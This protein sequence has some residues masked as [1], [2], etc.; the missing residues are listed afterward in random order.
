M[1]TFYFFL[2]LNEFPYKFL[3]D[4]HL[5]PSSFLVY[6][7]CVGSQLTLQWTSML[8]PAAAERTKVP[9]NYKDPFCSRRIHGG[10]EANFLPHCDTTES[11]SK[12]TR[13]DGILIGGNVVWSH[14]V[15]KHHD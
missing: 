14:L 11:P 6:I 5:L 8:T 1:A 7:D 12:S 15:S 2:S 4:E 13:V 9:R 3:L 10:G